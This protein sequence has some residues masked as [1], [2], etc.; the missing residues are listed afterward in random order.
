MFSSTLVIALRTPRQAQEAATQGTPSS[1]SVFYWVGCAVGCVVIY[2]FSFFTLCVLTCYRAYD[3]LRLRIESAMRGWMDGFQV[4]CSFMIAV[5]AAAGAVFL[6]IIKPKPWVRRDGLSLGFLRSRI[7]QITM[8][9]TWAS[10][11][12][13]QGPKEKMMKPA[14][15]RLLPRAI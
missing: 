6:H 5:E 13:E 4:R 1:P 8:W 10:V 9:P 7:F 14:T 12:A 2:V 3:G 15:A 11:S